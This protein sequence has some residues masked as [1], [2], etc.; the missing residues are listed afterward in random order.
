MSG[1]DAAPLT[2]EE[3]TGQWKIRI[4]LR[5]IDLDDAVLDVQYDEKLAKIAAANIN[6]SPIAVVPFSSPLAPMRSI[7][8]VHG[9]LICPV[10]CD[11]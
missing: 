3:L 9:V 5:D 7:A 8:P 4:T 10:L 2:I 6:V 11:V 1:A